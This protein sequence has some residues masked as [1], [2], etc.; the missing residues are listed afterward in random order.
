MLGESAACG[1]NVSLNDVKAIDR[2]GKR[3]QGDIG[4]SVIRAGS[5]IGDHHVLFAHPDEHLTLSHHARNRSIFAN[6]AVYAAEKLAE[7]TAGFYQ[8]KD[9]LDI[10]L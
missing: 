10:S 2:D 1:R 6:G 7:K 5:I 8:M 3:K 9:I 4:F